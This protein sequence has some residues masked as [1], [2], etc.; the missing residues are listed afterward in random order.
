MAS[1]GEMAPGNQV[2][3]AL[4]VE[5][6]FMADGLALLRAMADKL[7]PGIPHATRIAILQQT[8]ADTNGNLDPGSGN[9][10]A[11][12][13][14]RVMGSDTSRN[15]VVRKMECKSQSHFIIATLILSRSQDLSKSFDSDDPSQPV[16]AIRTVRHEQ[17]ESQLFLAQKNAS[18]KSGARGLQARKDLKAVEGKVQ[19]ARKL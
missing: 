11:T 1:L 2:R 12:V 10:H 6:C 15:E 8:D 13:L 9:Q 3:E 16:R 19:A 5:C 4:Q 7:V 14:E 17:L 18:L